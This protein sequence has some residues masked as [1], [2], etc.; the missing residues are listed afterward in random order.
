MEGKGGNKLVGRGLLVINSGKPRDVGSVT[1]SLIR[2]LIGKLSVGFTIE[3][4]PI[5]R[6][7]SEDNATVSLVPNTGRLGEDCDTGT[8]GVGS[9]LGREAGLTLFNS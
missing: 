5:G 3:L 6:D 2:S 8:V 4:N 1:T 9:P 7:E